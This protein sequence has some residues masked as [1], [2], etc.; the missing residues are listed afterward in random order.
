MDCFQPNYVLLQANVPKKGTESFANTNDVNSDL[1]TSG[2]HRKAS[3]SLRHKT[4]SSSNQVPY[5]ATSNNKKQK[6][7]GLSVSAIENVE[8]GIAQ[9]NILSRNKRG[10]SNILD[11][12]LDVKLVNADANDQEKLS[13]EGQ[14]PKRN[15]SEQ[16]NGVA[17]TR[18]HRASSTFSK[19]EDAP[20]KH[21]EKKTQQDSDQRIPNS[22]KKRNS[23]GKKGDQ[24]KDS[25][26]TSDDV[27]TAETV[28]L[29]ESPSSL[30]Q[31]QEEIVSVASQNSVSNELIGAIQSKN[32][33]QKAL[34]KE[35]AG[36]NNEESNVVVDTNASGS[37]SSVQEPSQ[38]S[39]QSPQELVSSKPVSAPTT[40]VHQPM[41]NDETESA[42]MRRANKE[43]KFTNYKFVPPENV[44][45]PPRNF[46][47][48]QPA[49]PPSM[50]MHHFYAANRPVYPVMYH[51][52]GAQYPS[53][54]P[55]HQNM[56]PMNPMSPMH[57]PDRF[58]GTPYVPYVMAPNQMHP[59][60][61]YPMYMTHQYLAYQRIASAQGMVSI[62]PAGKNP[63]IEQD[64]K[65][66]DV[67]MPEAVAKSP[68]NP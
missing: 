26:V 7:S 46:P 45:D 37:G 48:Y 10:D 12:R 55:F 47:V 2:S 24:L 42:N 4:A 13:V 38:V 49:Y 19:K 58:V 51:F 41:Q 43:L 25:H 30:Q 59:S 11:K 67:K 60:Q 64:G 22:A 14:T 16:G 57:Y 34:D 62:P 8:Q 66:D 31:N 61:N 21:R 18:K 1:A 65:I 28:L 15:G 39:T 3:K 9:Q 52:P 17:R 50:P 40:P 29:L 54:A 20:K 68:V 35:E 36:D 27:C 53:M 33:P 56:F 63:P 32:E 44:N 23:R 5:S 6:R